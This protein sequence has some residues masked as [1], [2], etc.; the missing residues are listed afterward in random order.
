MSGGETGASL[1]TAALDDVTAGGGSHTG[2]KSK[3]AFAAAIRGLKGS[4]HFSVRP[5]FSLFYN[6]NYPQTP[7]LKGI[8]R[9]CIL[10]IS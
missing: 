2:K 6:F 1:L 10:S 9:H 3:P 5:V 4:L 7:C 8:L